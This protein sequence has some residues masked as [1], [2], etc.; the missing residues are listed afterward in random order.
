MAKRK[1]K[2]KNN[3]INKIMLLFVLVLIVLYLIGQYCPQLIIIILLIIIFIPIYKIYIY[4]KKKRDEKRYKAERLM[5]TQTIDAILLEFFSNP[6]EFEKYIA[7]LFEHMGYETNVTSK[8]NDGGKDII[9][10]KDNNKYVVEVKLYNINNK[11][12]R[13]KI[14]KLHSAMIDSNANSAFF[15]TTSDFTKN[16]REYAN[17]FDIKLINGDVLAKIVQNI[18]NT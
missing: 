4:F 3:N 10:I 12:G 7:E 8:S 9:M 13:D 17:K 2:R 15:V 5:R 18:A 6:Y 1:R 14:Q 11:I 16:A